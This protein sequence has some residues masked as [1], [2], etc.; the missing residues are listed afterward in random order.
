[1]GVLAK[2]VRTEAFSK[3]QV[4]PLICIMFSHGLKPLENSASLQVQVIDNE[5]GILL[6]ASVVLHAMIQLFNARVE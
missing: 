4:C 2:S 3:Y 1:M 5:E 6:P